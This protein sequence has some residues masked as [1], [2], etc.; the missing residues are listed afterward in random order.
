MLTRLGEVDLATALAAAH[1]LYGP[2]F[3]PEVTLKALSYFDDGN[4]CDLPNDLK[5]RLV[6]AAREV[7]LDH[8]ASRCRLSASAF[9]LW[10]R[11]MKAI[12]V[13]PLT[14]NIARRIIW[15]EPPDHALADPI[16]LMSYAM[17]Y[18]GHEDM[19]VIRRY[20][21]DDD[22][23]DALDHAPPGIIDPRSWAYWNS[24]MGRYPPPPLPV[25]SFSTAADGSICG[26]CASRHSTD[27]RPRGAA[28]GGQGGMARIS[29]A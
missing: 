7:D 8:A 24:K 25:R 22:M 11:V 16:R 2:T 1:A 18:A 4:L 27:C 20:V 15:F 12:P 23:R 6:E 29:R 10:V 9:G 17:T 21:S 28:T 14:L 13:T 5:L 26:L 3:N 19:R